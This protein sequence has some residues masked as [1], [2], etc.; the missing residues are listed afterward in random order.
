MVLHPNE[1][2]KIF[3]PGLLITQ[4]S[5]EKIFLSKKII[6]REDYFLISIGGM[7]KHSISFNF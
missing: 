3:L 6:F 5:E 4:F 1:N 7:A 2:Q